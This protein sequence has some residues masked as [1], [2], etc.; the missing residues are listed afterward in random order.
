MCDQVQADRDREPEPR[1]IVPAIDV[2]HDVQAYE[3]E[4]SD[5]IQGWNSKSLCV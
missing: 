4:D 2:G 5:R 1:H 3:S